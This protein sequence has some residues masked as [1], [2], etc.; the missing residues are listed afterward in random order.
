MN[1]QTRLGRQ[2]PRRPGLH[3]A[4][5]AALPE[6][7]RLLQAT[8]GHDF[9]TYKTS[10]LVRRIERRMQLRRLAT[11][12]DYLG[13]LAENPLEARMLIREF[14]IGVTRFFRDPAVWEQIRT[15]IIP[16]LIA[17]TAGEGTIRAWI[18]GCATGEDA[19]SLAMLL[20]EV[21]PPPVPGRGRRHRVQIFA[22]DLNPQ[23]IDRA[24]RGRYPRDIE[25][26]VAPPRLARFFQADGP[27]FQ[28]RQDLREL[29]TFAPHSL[30]ADPPFTRIDL[31]I[32]R[33]L[34]I[35]L[36]PQVHAQL[37][38]RFHCCLNPGGHLVLGSSEA[39]GTA[40]DLFLTL[41]GN[42]QI[43]RRLEVTCPPRRCGFATRISP[44]R[45][46]GQ[47]LPAID[48]MHSLDPTYAAAVS[49]LLVQ[50]YGPAALLCHADGTILYACGPAA[51]W[52]TG[53]PAQGRPPHV[54]LLRDGLRDAV[55][56]GLAEVARTSGTLPRRLP[57]P[58]ADGSAPVVELQLQVLGE[59]AALR[60]L[61]LVTWTEDPLGIATG[62]GE[63]PAAAQLRIRT[64]EQELRRTRHELQL[65]REE[66]QASREELTSTNEELQ[67]T[68][69]ELTTSAEE[70]RTMNEEL[71]RARAEAEEAL[72]RYTDLFD[73]API[74]Y[75]ALDGRGAIVQANAV[76]ADLLEQ[77]RGRL[78][79]SPFGLFV[80]EADRPRFRA[81][82]NAAFASAEAQSCEVAL[83]REQAPPRIVQLSALAA[84]DGQ[85]CRV[86]A[87]DVSAIRQAEAALRDRDE[88][89]RMTITAS[90][91]GIWQWDIPRNDLQWSPE[92]KAMFGLPAEALVSFALARE[93]IH[94]DDRAQTEELTRQILDHGQDLTHEHRVVWPDGSVHWIGAL[95]RVYRDAAGM[96]LR[97]VGVTMDITER[98]EAEK[99]LDLERAKLEA[100]L[101][102]MTAAVFLLDGQGGNLWM[103]AAG[104]TLLA[105]PLEADLPTA[106]A[107]HLPAF[108]LLDPA[109]RVLDLAE[110]PARRALRGDFVRDAELT[111]RHRATGRQHFCLITVT[112]VRDPEH[113]IAQLVC[114]V[115]DVTERHVAQEEQ[116]AAQA[117]IR[118]LEL[119]L[120]EHALVSIT[121]QSGRIIY[122][123]DKFC[124]VSKYARDELLGQDHRLINSGYHPPEF[125]S[126]LWQTLLAGQ[127]WKGEIRNRAKDGSLYWVETTIVPFRKA[128]GTPYQYVAIRKDITL[129]RETMAKLAQHQRFLKAVTDGFAGLVAY[130]SRDLRCTFASAGHLAWFGQPAEQVVGMALPELLGPALFARAQPYV[131]QVLHGRAQ[132]FPQTMVKANGEVG[133]L[134]VQFVP[135]HAGDEVAGFYALLSDITAIKQAEEALQR[136]TELLESTQALAQV[137]G[138][139][140]DLVQ[141]EV[142]WNRETHR[143]HG[144]AAESFHPTIAAWVALYPDA[145]G[146]TLAKAFDQAISWGEGFDLELA[147]TGADRQQRWV[148]ITSQI[149]SRDDRPVKLIGAVQDI[150]ERCRLQLDLALARDKALEASRLKSEFLSTMSHEIRTPMNGVIGVTELL[151]STPLDPAQREIVD[152]L[153]SSGENLLVIINDILDFSKIE[154]GKLRVEPAPF[155]LPTVLEETTALFAPRARSKNLDLVLHCAP[156]LAGNLNG[157]GGRIRQVVANLLGNAVKFTARGTITV[158]ATVVEQRDAWRRVRIAVQDT[159][160]GIS[161][162]TQ[163]RLFQPFTQG[164]GS[165][166][167]RHGGTGLGLAISRQLVELMG[168]T[169]GFGSTP[170]VGSTFWFEL[171]LEGAGSGIRTAQIPAAATGR[172]ATS[173]RLLVADDN[174]ANQKVAMMLLTAMGHEVD[175]AQDGAEALLRLATTR[176]DAV[177]LDCQMPV[178]DG[179]ET[180][181]RIRAGAVPNVDPRIPLIALTAAA[182]AED[183]SL[184]QAAGMDDHLCKPVRSADLAQAFRALG[185]LPEVAADSTR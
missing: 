132:I 58:Q 87:T 156:A 36:N 4:A 52:L 41:A 134:L 107:G 139:E 54:D 68:N 23:A 65:A 108:D 2:N 34:L 31:L 53:S 146:T 174:A 93:L 172:N 124:R 180:A 83:W 3:D 128:D 133:T 59:P 168:G 166:T 175:L 60:G 28:V 98:K 24:R 66:M 50:R 18:P 11:I 80:T 183:R 21:L 129:R 152:I 69:E 47:P 22:T 17:A 9:T 145:A 179:F 90:N 147:M 19:Y 55:R 92:C 109:G 43:Y 184:T 141:A 25:S 81:C 20:T 185:L 113:S 99:A 89:L 159:G 13:Q 62:E 182:M 42:H 10:T 173:L 26:A 164:D 101:A 125:F 84:A 37:L 70:L 154:A 33:N 130:W 5:T 44:F 148:H 120:D 153:R 126:D 138:W 149:I 177:L 86:V 136:T 117:I 79:G 27:G 110:W 102:N 150:T 45:N 111:I 72:L 105:I 15:E 6:V 40:G 1:A 142:F 135:D 158:E 49:T 32:C 64:L 181:R 8:T 127:T 39:I 170:G 82:L 171:D 77:E 46:P 106:D 178:L 137:G 161:H 12:A 103:N 91:L 48:P 63:H 123:N 104:R 94:P 96:P 118:N 30:L 73:S 61:V 121:D 116:R 35:Y 163:G 71:V 140:I 85:A 176:Y 167:R 95:G 169:I 76:G 57:L 162:E 112:P 160:E 165:F 131:A 157:D 143:I 16:G 119:A 14:L 122:A 67:S 51:S 74:G 88:T 115:H 100:I 151:Q 7:L 97:M 75:Y 56:D 144:T 155:S 29:I 38:P 114:T 78:V